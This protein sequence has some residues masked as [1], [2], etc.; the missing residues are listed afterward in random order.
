[1]TDEMRFEAPGPAPTP[2]E[3]A[4]PASPQPD[5]TVIV[6][7]KIKRVVKDRGMRSDGRLVGALNAAVLAMLAKAAEHAK[8]EGRATVRPQDLAA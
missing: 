3:E 5:P 1:M 7:S 2:A 8:A 4:A 6:A